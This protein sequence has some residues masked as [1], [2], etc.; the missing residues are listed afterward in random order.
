[1]NETPRSILDAERQLSPEKANNWLFDVSRQIYKE[2]PRQDRCFKSLATISDPVEAA[3]KLFYTL[4]AVG[5]MRELR[6][7]REPLVK[8]L[9][10]NQLW[11]PGVT[12]DCY[13]EG[14]SYHTKYI[15]LRRGTDWIEVAKTRFSL[16]QIKSDIQY[17]KI[18]IAP[19]DCH[20]GAAPKPTVVKPK[21]RTHVETLL[22]ETI[23]FSHLEY[24]I[25][26]PLQS[27]SKRLCIDLEE[28]DDKGYPLH[29]NRA[30][31][32][33]VSP[34]SSAPHVPSPHVPLTQWPFVD[35][36]TY[37]SLISNAE[38][39]IKL[40]PLHRDEFSVEPGPH[41]WREGD[42]QHWFD[43]LQSACDRI[44]VITLPLTY[45][46]LK[47]QA[48]EGR[49]G[50][51]KAQYKYTPE[52]EVQWEKTVVDWDDAAAGLPVIEGDAI[53]KTTDGEVVLYKL[54]TA[55]VDGWEDAELGA[56]FVG[57]Y[58]LGSMQALQ[59]DQLISL[60]A[61]LLSSPYR[62]PRN[63]TQ[64]MGWFPPYARPK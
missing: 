49:K 9:E 19:L 32:P 5:E 26:P 54:D 55:L 30:D 35:P 59:H 14:V 40:P 34:T 33:P 52:E 56:K 44:K 13:L 2:R 58:E 57:A 20:K 46:E 37:P 29:P 60:V 1:M 41:D 31:Q 63:P 22:K 21:K 11:L 4:R 39:G 18:P 6:D 36:E 12:I 45:A 3:W 43:A 10:E 8:H 38:T 24:A 28:Y 23:D 17:P 42:I 64:S 62:E 25:L 53:L 7:W 27:P 15:D 16:A 48:E 50:K 61:A 51:R 47:T